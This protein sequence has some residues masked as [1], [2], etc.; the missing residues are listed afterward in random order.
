MCVCSFHVCVFL[1]RELFFCSVLSL[2]LCECLFVSLWVPW[3]FLCSFSSFFFCVRVGGVFRDV[4]G[5]DMSNGACM[6]AKTER[7]RT[8]VK[9]TERW[10]VARPTQ[11]M[12]DWRGG[13]TKT[14]T[15]DDTNSEI[16]KLERRQMQDAMSNGMRQDETRYVTE[17]TRDESGER[18]EEDE[19]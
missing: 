4:S 19:G 1:C 8:S 11:C 9:T 2:C 16:K 10:S 17:G 13:E 15:N 7:D 6:T 12:K 14:K 3:V 18:D 5:L